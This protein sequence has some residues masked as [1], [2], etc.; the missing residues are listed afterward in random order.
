MKKLKNRKDQR[1]DQRVKEDAIRKIASKEQPTNLRKDRKVSREL[2]AQL[3]HSNMMED[4]QKRLSELKFLR[5]I[6]EDDAEK[7]AITQEIKALIRNP[8]IVQIEVEDSDEEVEVISNIPTSATLL[9]TTETNEEDPHDRPQT[10]EI[11]GDEAASECGYDIAD[12]DNDDSNNQGNRSDNNQAV[13]STVDT[14]DSDSEDSSVSPQIQTSTPTPFDNIQTRSSPRRS[15]SKF[16]LPTHPAVSA[17]LSGPLRMPDPPCTSSSSSVSTSSKSKKKPA[18]K[19]PAPA[20]PATACNSPVED[21]F[22]MMTN[23][24]RRKVKR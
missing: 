8:L 9:A 16:T 24:K 2:N 12:E 22:Q 10:L 1:H 20:I 19:S 17:T 6:E 11:W 14:A 3:K 5:E 13:D 23:N 7:E 18:I 15:S 21:V 4:R